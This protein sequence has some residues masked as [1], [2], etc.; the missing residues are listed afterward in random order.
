[1]DEW[2]LRWLA[3]TAPLLVGQAPRVAAELL[4][5]AVERSPAGSSRHESLLC[6]LAEALYRVGDIA[7][8]E[9]V[10]S[11]ALADVAEPDL[12]VDLHW[13]LAQ[14]RTMAGRFPESLAALGQALASPG[15]LGRRRARLL[16]L[17]SRAHRHLGQVEMAGDAAAAGLEEATHAADTWATAWALHMLTGVAMMQGRTADALPLFD[18]AL[19]ATQADPALTDLRLL[20]QLNKALA[21]GDLDQY[22]GAF[23]AARQAQQLAGRAGI[24]VRLALA[25]CCLGQLLFDTGHWD[26]ALARGRRPGGR[27]QGPGSCLLR[28]WRR[29]GDL[30]PPR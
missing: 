18:R 17:T 22:E 15:V 7:E 9:R 14:C 26:E 29:C 4:G 24:M 5:H 21:L 20:L 6:C 30:V 28:S 2:I 11:R 8:A 10:A 25:Q 27:Q 23:A 13:T 19:T 3:R 16:V 1:M 12:R